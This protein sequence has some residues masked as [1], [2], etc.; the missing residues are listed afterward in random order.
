MPDLLE[1]VR[2]AVDDEE[3]LEPGD[4]VHAAI[5]VIRP[6]RP[7][8]ADDGARAVQLDW[9]VSTRTA[10]ALTD[11]RLVF[12]RTD[13]N[14]DPRQIVHVQALEQVEDLVHE[15]TDVGGVR[16]V[17]LTLVLEDGSVIPTEAVVE[18]A[19][20]DELDRFVGLL[21]QRLAS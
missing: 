2:K 12:L 20:G 11:D 19:D 15:E 7:A 5:V 18:D 21:E 17:D 14:G 1:R 9:P 6:D 16:T 10:L 4:Q 13:E 3:L 8:S